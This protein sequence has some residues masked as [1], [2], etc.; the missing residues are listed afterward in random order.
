MSS[1][2]DRMDAAQRTSDFNLAALLDVFVLYRRMMA[3]IFCVIVAGGIAWAFLSDPVYQADLLVQIEE[4]NLASSARS[5]FGDIAAMFD[6]KSSAE[7]E[8]QVLASRLVLASAVDQLQL[9]IEAKPVR[10]PLFGNAIA[11][12]NV[13]N[14]GAPGIFGSGGFNWG[15]A[16]I[17]VDA[18][19]V[20]PDQEGESYYV[21]A[22]E[23]GQYRLSGPGIEEG[24]VARIGESHA[25]KTESG[26]IVLDVKSLTGD[27]GARFELVRQSRV[28]AIDVLQREISV[29]HQ[30]RDTSDMVRVRLRGTDRQRVT[31]T[32]NAIARAYVDQNGARKTDEAAHSRAVLLRDL[33]ELRTNLEMAEATL[34][35]LR[36]KVRSVDMDDEGKTLVQQSA[37]NEAQ[38]TQLLQTRTDLVSRFSAQ[39][40]SVVALDQQIAILRG[41]AEQFA[42]RISE[43]PG[44]QRELVTAQRDVL[45]RKDLYLNQLNNISQLELLRAGRPGNVLMIDSAIMPDSPIPMRRPMIAGLALVLG[46]FAAVAAAYLRE[47]LFGGVSHPREIEQS[48]GL[49]VCAVVPHAAHPKAG[50]SRLARRSQTSRRLLA[51]SDPADPAIES[52]R[53]LRTT[54]QFSMLDGKNNV[55]LFTSPSPLIGKSFVS[56]NFAAVLATAGKRVLLVDADLRRANLSH[57]FGQGTRRGFCDVLAGALTLEAAIFP[58]E[59]DNLSFLPAGSRPGNAADLLTSG[60]VDAIMQELAAR[61]DVVVLDTA[62][63]LAVPDASILAPFA[64]GNV[65]ILARAGVTKLGELEETARRL[66]QVGVDVTGVILNG[67]DPRAGHFRYGT[68]YGTYRYTADSISGAPVFPEERREVGYVKT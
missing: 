51:L 62:P 47:L 31:D 22:L 45:V 19:N 8:M 53:G 18:F 60:P 36:T 10:L 25:F 27:Q 23:G 34:T 50:W 55:V 39:Y 61:Y 46:C 16:A 26:P 21:T 68:R 5:P 1:S 33:P 11:R 58:T 66:E 52:L 65:F 35:T 4:T 38:L 59:Q 44:E 48:A 12:A 32:L 63:L 6:V 67:I 20:P 28:D 3:W 64:R 41:R 56:S 7:T 37:A 24:E 54:L 42:Q 40:P 49:R 9:Y 30:G 43:L 2:I 14:I 57:R 15:K 13:K 29:D 17:S